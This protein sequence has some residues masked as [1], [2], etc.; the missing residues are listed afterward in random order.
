MSMSLRHWRLVLVSAAFATTF[1]L[2]AA[3]D[4]EISQ[5]VLLGD[6]GSLPTS[7]QPLY[8]WSGAVQFVP[9]AGATFF[10]AWD[11]ARGQE[12]WRSDGTPAGSAPLRDLCPGACN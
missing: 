11:G 3:A 9:F 8:E 1:G 2:A 5:P 6:I 10:D 12:L 4:A 7:V